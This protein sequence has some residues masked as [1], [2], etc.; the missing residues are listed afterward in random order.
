MHQV[1]HLGGGEVQYC[2]DKARCVNRNGFVVVDWT[3]HEAAEAY[4]LRV[5]GRRVW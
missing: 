3:T 4:A 5:F 2:G 1:K